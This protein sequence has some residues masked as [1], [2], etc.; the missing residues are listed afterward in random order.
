MPERLCKHC[1]ESDQQNFYKNEKSSCKK[2]SIE[3][4]K[5]RYHSGK[6]SPKTILERFNEKYNVDISGCWILNGTLNTNGYGQIGINSKI[7]SAH[8]LA[9]ELFKGTIPEGLFIC[10][11]CDTPGFVNPEHLFLGIHQDNMDDMV[12]KGR[13]PKQHGEGCV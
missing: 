10:H 9:Y 6:Q 8:R 1:G 5:A 12:A 2:C 3:K 13:S 7:H 11:T 4:S